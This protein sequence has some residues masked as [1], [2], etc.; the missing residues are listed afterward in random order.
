MALATLLQI[1][2]ETAILIAKNICFSK[3]VP[4]F[5]DYMCKNCWTA[6]AYAFL[7]LTLYLLASSSIYRV[8]RACGYNL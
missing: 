7:L 6:H 5:C 2:L 1:V 8:M 4:L 3:P